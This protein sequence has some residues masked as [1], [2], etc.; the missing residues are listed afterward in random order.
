MKYN[1]VSGKSVKLDKSGITERD[2]F[3]TVLIVAVD[4]FQHDYIII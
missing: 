1:P 2:E 4:K 3:S